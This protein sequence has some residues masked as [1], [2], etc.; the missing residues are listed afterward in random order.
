MH[1]RLAEFL[2][3]YRAT[4]HATTNISPS[5]LFQNK[6]IETHFDLLLPNISTYVIKMAE[7]S[8]RCCGCGPRGVCKRY[9]CVTSGNPCSNCQPS[10]SGCCLN[11]SP[12]APTVALSHSVRSDTS[13]PLSSISESLQSTAAG[14]TQV[15]VAH[16]LDPSLADDSLLAQAT[17]ILSVP[18]GVPLTQISFVWGNLDAESFSQSVNAAY[19]EVVHWKRNLFAVPF[20]R[21]GKKFVTELSRPFRA[22]AEATAL[23]GV[24]LTAT[25][26]MPILLLQNPSPSSKPK[27]HALY[28]DRCC[29]LWEQ[30]DI[31]SLV[32]EGRAIQKRLRKSHS[33]KYQQENLARKFANLMFRGDISGAINLLS[34]K[35]CSKVLHASDHID[36]GSGDSTTVLDAL[37]EKHPPASPVNINALI[38]PGGHP[39]EIHP[40]IF[41]QITAQSIRQAALHTKGAAGPSAFDAL[42]WRRLCTSFKSVSS[43]LCHSLALIARRIC[44]Y[45]VNPKALL[46][47][48]LLALDKCPGIR[49]IGICETHRRIISKAIL[50]VTRSDLREAA[51]AEQLCAGQIAGIEAAIHSVR[52]AFSDDESDAV[53]L[54]DA[55]NA[56]NTSN[57]QVA[58]INVR[59]LCPLH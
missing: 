40:V 55:T 4:P 58:L 50:A 32:I 13:S 52:C 10:R 57:R 47:C 44:S 3:D 18:R 11:M 48:R 12:L 46:A 9:V 33:S 25:T 38:D 19:S 35:D 23:E 59:H 1:H 7:G 17:A 51:G 34:S 49:P 28:L 16:S 8:R 21:V 37:K 20:G 2:F 43:D 30:G 26:I 15:P 56:F 27:D 53:L 39:E 14:V 42:Q 54:V 6:H 24:A 22:Y 31:N 29:D 41:D 5:E 36:T 45:F